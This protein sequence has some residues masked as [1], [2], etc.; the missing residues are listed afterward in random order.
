[1]AAPLGRAFKRWDPSKAAVLKKAGNK[2]ARRAKEKAARI[3]QREA[4][5]RQRPDKAE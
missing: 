2:K 1:M 4:R 3:K 5:K